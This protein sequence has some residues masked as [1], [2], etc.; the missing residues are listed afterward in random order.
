[1]LAP[2]TVAA[3]SF[4]PVAPA[5][6]APVSRSSVKMETISDLKTLANDLNPVSSSHEECRNAFYAGDADITF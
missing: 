3:A 2:F 4:A 5:A 6:R 1:M